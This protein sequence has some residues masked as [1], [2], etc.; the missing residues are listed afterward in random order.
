MSICSCWD[1]TKLKW[2]EKHHTI[3]IKEILVTVSL[4]LPHPEGSIGLCTGEMEHWYCQKCEPNHK[5]LP[6]VIPYR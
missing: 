4:D 1:I 6:E 3:L 5:M 2:C